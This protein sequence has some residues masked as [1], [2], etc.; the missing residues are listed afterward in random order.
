MSRLLILLAYVWPAVLLPCS[1]AAGGDAPIFCTVSQQGQQVAKR[2]AVLRFSGRDKEQKHTIFL[3]S[4]RAGQPLLFFADVTTPVCI[5]DLCKPVRVELYWDL[6][7]NYAGYAVP[8]KTPLT[9]F[10]H[11][12]FEPADY[13]KL[14]QVLSNRDSILGRKTLADMFDPNAPTDPRNLTYRG[15]QVDAVSGATVKDIRQ[16]IVPGAL[17]SCY[18]IWHLVHGDVRQQMLAHLASIYNPTI[19]RR[20]LDSTHAGYQLYAVQRMEDAEFADH[21]SRVLDVF[22]SADPAARVTILEKLPLTVW[23]QEPTTRVLYGLF[24][25]LDFDTKTQL[26]QNLTHAHASAAQLLCDH[27]ETMNKKQLKAFLAYLTDNP[28]RLT[29]PIKAKLERIAA[30]EKYAYCYVVDAFLQD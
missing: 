3:L 17:Y 1:T 14:D 21:V 13:A 9:K 30:A 20:F 11:T 16:S 29:E 24:R 5:N 18:A 27:V 2:E 15:Q 26:I 23:Q 22:R 6:L 10:D 25:T 12:P 19:A 4:D 7:G 28:K 8:S